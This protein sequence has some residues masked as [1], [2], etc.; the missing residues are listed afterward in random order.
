[1]DRVETR[2]ALHAHGLDHPAGI[3]FA[4]RDPT[5]N[6][7]YD[8]HTH[9][10]HQLVYAIAGPSQ[11]ETA[12][13]R[14]VLPQGRAAWI[15]ARTRHRSLI[16]GPDDASLFFSPDVVADASGRVRILA[17]SPL[18]REMV[19]F[20]MRW[21]LGASDG[22]PVAESF[23][24]TLALLC[25]EWLA[26]ELPLFLPS[27]VHPGIRRAM[28]YAAADLGTATQAGAV[29]AA[30]LSERTFRRHFAQEAGMGWQE[31]LMQARI[32][33]AMG[34]LVEGRRVTDVAAEVGYASLSA[35]AKS[36][37]Q[38]S[39]ETPTRFKLRHAAMISKPGTPPVKRRLTLER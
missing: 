21:P 1:M 20:A 14:H 17:A 34:L 24:R 27:A 19:L 13:G 38:L 3:G 37:T 7:V 23:F 15:P 6:A 5:L 18:M 28:D 29:A 11:I 33:M 8:W 22:D 9:V 31:W 39:G 35:F 25:G 12:Q 30:A 4:V 16:T 32:L 36:F 10:Y 26:S 2:S